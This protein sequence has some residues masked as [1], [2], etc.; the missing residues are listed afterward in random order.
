MQICILTQKNNHASIPPLSFLQ[1]GCPS[2]CPTNSA[3]ALKANLGLIQWQK[4]YAHMC[5]CAYIIIYVKNEANSF[6]SS[7]QA[8]Q[9]LDH[10]YLLTTT[11]KCALILFINMFLVST[12][13]Q[14][15]KS[16]CLLTQLLFISIMTILPRLLFS[17]Q[18]VNEFAAGNKLLFD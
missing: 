11:S 18:L 14:W 8:Y 2:C 12:N 1:D 16:Y 10:I 5:K 13:I 17:I 7:I 6:L 3:K 4:S 15:L 9:F